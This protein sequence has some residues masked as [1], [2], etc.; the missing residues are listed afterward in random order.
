MPKPTDAP[1]STLERRF[2]QG[3]DVTDLFARRRR[4]P[5]P[6]GEMNGSAVSAPPEEAPAPDLEEQNEVSPAR[7]PA[8][9]HASR[10]RAETPQTP[11]PVQRPVRHRDLAIPPFRQLLVVTPEFERRL[12]HLERRE[13]LARSGLTRRL[14]VAKAIDDALAAVEHGDTGWLTFPEK[15]KPRRTPTTSWDSMH[16]NLNV[17]ISQ[18]HKSAIG[19]L[20]EDCKA[21]GL[22]MSY[23]QFI[24]QAVEHF[25]FGQESR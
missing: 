19:R 4:S 20:I 11:R 22:W 2:A 12:K 15:A 23:S 6:A 7:Q 8:N 3:E 9:Q 16:R 17:F 18:A 25:I 1:S 10:A 14:I 5:A 13:Q 24:T 21:D